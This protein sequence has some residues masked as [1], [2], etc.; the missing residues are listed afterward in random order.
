M[1]PSFLPPVWLLQ[2]LRFDAVI[3]IHTLALTPH[4]GHIHDI[5]KLRNLPLRKRSIVIRMVIC[6]ISS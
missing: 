5:P 1:L 2:A 6:V 4:A 3:I